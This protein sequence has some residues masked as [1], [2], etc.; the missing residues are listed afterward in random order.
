MQQNFTGPRRALVG[1]T[2]VLVATGL[3]AALSAC[4][5]IATT[6]IPTNASA[7]APLLQ[8]SAAKLAPGAAFR[9]CPDCPEMVVVPPGEFDMGR[10]G[11]EPERYE[12]PVRR[13][14]VGYAFAAGRTEITNA[15]YR[16]FVEASG[17]APSGE[18]CQIPAPGGRSLVSLPG[19]SWANPGYGRPIRD[20]EPAACLRWSD[21]KSY[22]SW[23]AGV[24]GQRYRLLTE[25]EWEYAARAGTTGVHT[26][27]EDLARACREANI[28][29]LSAAKLGAPVAHGPAECD[30]GFPTVAP[31]GSLAPNAFGLHDM[32][33]NVWEWV[34]DCYEMPYGAT[35]VDGS[36]QLTKGCDRR[37][38]RGGGWRSAYPRQI[39]TFR[40]RDPE[41][42]TSQI[43]GFRVARDL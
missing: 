19:T 24:T 26:W 32:I 1:M 21:A 40:G 25:A 28:F 37:G 2:V 41:S 16:R 12:G 38:S 11:G 35:P 20:D 30:D 27:G 34:E 17:H 13:V 42:L 31:V 10:D 5:S 8:G 18:G 14:R 9:D 23:L 33:G 43:F 7:T 36:A 6:A 15:Q 29:D 39:P 3:G 4:S 22:V